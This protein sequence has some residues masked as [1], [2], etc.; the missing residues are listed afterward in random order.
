MMAAEVRNWCPT[1]VVAMYQHH[2][3]LPPSLMVLLFY[4]LMY[5]A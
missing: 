1:R 4:H 5:F 3:N 2:L